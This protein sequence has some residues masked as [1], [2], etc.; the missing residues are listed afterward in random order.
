MGYRT[1]YCFTSMDLFD[2]KYKK[3]LGINMKH[4]RAYKQDMIKELCSQIFTYFFYLV[5]LDIIEN[6]VTFVLPLFGDQEA[7]IYVKMFEDEKFQ[8]MY[9][10][11]VFS[12]IDF[13]KSGFKGY[14][15]YLQYTYKGGI[16]EK[17]MYI[18]NNLKNIFYE[19][20]NNGKQY[21]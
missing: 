20:I 13:L 1:D 2:S 9:S 19:N 21:F 6:N 3:K 8:R 16:R 18:S 10:K 17:P 5:I 11:G 4:V 7:C 14:R 12:G 15:L